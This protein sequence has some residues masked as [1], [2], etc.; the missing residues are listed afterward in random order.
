LGC[1]LLFALC[2]RAQTAPAQQ[3]PPPG[4]TILHTGTQLVIVDVGIA[5]RNGNPIHGLKQGDL[6]LTEDK[7][8][9]QVRH[10]EEH[11]ADD[12][13]TGPALPPMPPGMF[14]NYTAVPPD[15]TL[16]VLLIDTLNT[17][18][19]DQSFLRNQLAEFVKKAKPG[20]HIAIFGMSSR[21]YLLQGFTSD[22][23]TLKDAVEHKLVPRAS[24]LL[25]DPVGTNGDT[26]NMADIASDADA[27]AE[28][29]ASLQQ[30]EAE[31]QSFQTQMRV[32]YTLD[33]FNA[34]AHYLSGFPG[35]KNLIWFSG[36]FPLSLSPDPSI[37]NPFAVMADMEE[38][39]RETTNLLTR[40]QVAVFPVDARGLMVLP[41]LSAANSGSKY[42]KN[43]AAFS[44]DVQKFSQSQADEHSTMGQMA[45]ATGGQAY[46]NT[47]GLAD[48][49][50][51]AIDSGSNYYTLTYSPANHNWNGGY[52]N[53]KVSLSDAAKQ[54]GLTLTYRRGYYAVDPN[55][56][57]KPD[58]AASLSEAAAAA[59][60]S[61]SNYARLAMQRGAPTPNDILIKLRVVPVSDKPDDT[62]APGNVLNPTKPLKPPF[63][64]Y[65]VDLVALTQDFSFTRN[66][67]NTLSDSIEV[68]IDLYDADGNLLN[69]A[70][71][72]AQIKLGADKFKQLMQSGIQY[73]SQISTPAKGETFLLIGV[74]DLATNHF[75]VVEI[76]TS[77]IN[78][79]PP[80][81]AAKPAHPAA[82]SDKP[83]P[84]KP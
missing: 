22:P 59:P 79:L 83:A 13:P 12:H 80:L 60:G 30:F 31:R 58:Q 56:A 36:S 25:D 46:Y 67:D 34:L 76:P 32:R 55:S 9:Q 61:A 5:D 63:R 66:P 7:T 50:A 45:E 44:A 3:E 72:T 38:E 42:V 48:A 54:Q 8:P 47:N 4:T 37:N 70:G 57:K 43:P 62:L 14:T 28:V 10:F 39:F 33:S 84:A 16:N 73:H 82:S 26:P 75:G 78:R 19:N 11:R 71:Q 64:R 41:A 53:I 77:R 15:S 51:R 27:P 18:M 29:V 24:S 52:R 35:R 68:K 1:A 23:E 17:P 81:E 6:V 69:V 65:Q 49:T 40:A 2:T 74:H 20:T 21:L